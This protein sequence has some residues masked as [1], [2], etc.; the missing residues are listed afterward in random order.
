[1][2]LR[3]LAGVAPFGVKK[4]LSDMKKQRGRPHISKMLKVHVYAFA[5]DS[6]ISRYRRADQ[7]G[8][9]YQYGIVI[10]FG[11]EAFLREF[12]PV[13]FNTGETDFER[14]SFWSDRLHLNGFTRRLGR[15]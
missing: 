1:M 4:T 6:G 9:E 3:F 5:D 14:V 15:G 11:R 8:A 7:V 12:N 10:E 2:E 13:A